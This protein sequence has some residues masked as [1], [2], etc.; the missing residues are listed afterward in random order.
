MMN[1]VFFIVFFL[2]SGIVFGAMKEN[3]AIIAFKGDVTESESITLT[4]NLIAKIIKKDVYTVVERSQMTEILKEQGFQ[5]A[6][7][8]SDECAVEVGQLLGVRKIIISNLGKVGNLYSLSLKIINVETGAIIRTVTT[9]VKGG[10]EAVLKVGIDKVVEDFC[11]IPMTAEQ[12]EADY[13]K[14]KKIKTI[15]AASIG[16]VGL[17]LGGLATYFWIDK[18]N[19]HDNYLNAFGSDISKYK[20]ARDDAG[21]KAI[22][23]TA[24]S[25]TLLATSTTLFI[26]KTKKKE[27]HKVSFGGFITPE[28]GSLQLTYNF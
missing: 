26:I 7:C 5:Q 12:I 18:S 1:R 27:N 8:T 21:T 11:W 3:I 9:D 20:T 23:F 13:K 28:N 16:G 22:I 14:R 6:G 24:A 19:Q 15:L 17:G 4:D 10:M 25:G 2:Y